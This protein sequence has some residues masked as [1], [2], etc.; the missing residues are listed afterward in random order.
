MKKL[1]WL[2]ATL[3]LLSNFVL[4][5]EKDP[6]MSEENPKFETFEMEQGDS[7]Y[8]MKK[9][10]LGIYLSGENRSQ[11]ESELKDLQAAHMAHIGKMAEDK[12]VCIAGPFEG[13]TEKRGLLIF[14]VYTEQEA[15][16]LMSQD[17]MVKAGRL[18]F[19]IQGF[20]AAKD[21]KLF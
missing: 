9:Y 11:E 5:Q 3:C 17:P 2:I 6:S 12:K 4:A 1:T 18:K 19:E 13:D 16:D 7:T 10:F 20:W 21:S 14:S 15:I 8:V